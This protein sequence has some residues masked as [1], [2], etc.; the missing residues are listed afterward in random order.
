MILGVE[1]RKNLASAAD[2]SRYF[3]LPSTQISNTTALQE[4]AMVQ[5]GLARATILGLAAGLV[6]ALVL[7]AAFSRPV[8]PEG[9]SLEV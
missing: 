3:Q 1:N 6:I 4:R 2:I 7:V 5:K 8:E 9:S